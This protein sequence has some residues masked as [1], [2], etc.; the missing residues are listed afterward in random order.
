MGWKLGPT[1]IRLSLMLTSASLDDVIDTERCLVSSAE[2]D[3]SCRT[4][5]QG[6]QTMMAG[7]GWPDGMGLRKP[8]LPWSTLVVWSPC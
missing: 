6:H 1:R 3:G 7:E 5:V 4:Q 8:V 2:H